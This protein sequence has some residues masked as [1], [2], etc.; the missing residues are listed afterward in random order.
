METSGE[1]DARRREVGAAGEGQ[2]ADL[3]SAREHEDEPMDEPLIIT[4]EETSNEAGKAN[5]PKSATKSDQQAGARDSDSKQSLASKERT[6]AAQYE[7]KH[8]AETED[9]TARTV[10]PTPQEQYDLLTARLKENDNGISRVEIEHDTRLIF[11]SIYNGI[12]I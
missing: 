2:R 1:D 3:S 4:A 8:A 6:R 12:R 11:S 7:S 9:N 5:E 10:D